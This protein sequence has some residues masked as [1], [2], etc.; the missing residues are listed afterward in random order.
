MKFAYPLQ[1]LNFAVVY[2]I[3]H[4]MSPMTRVRSLEERFYIKVAKLTIYPPHLSH[5]TRKKDRENL[6]L[7]LCE[8]KGANQL[9]VNIAAEMC[10]RYGKIIVNQKFQVSSHLLQLYSPVCV[11]HGRN[12]PPPP[13]EDNAHNY[14]YNALTITTP[15]DRNQGQG[16]K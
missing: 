6:F 12:P 4:V 3:H 9:R 15:F 1:V 7:A 8:K 13:P 14:V 2:F 5:H 16:C 11:R 10:H